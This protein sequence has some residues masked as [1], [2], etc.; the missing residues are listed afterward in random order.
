VELIPFVHYFE[1]F[2]GSNAAIAGFN[3]HTRGYIYD[4]YCSRV[5]HQLETQAD[6]IR[7]DI[8]L[9]SNDVTRIITR[10]SI[11][12]P[13]SL[14]EIE[15]EK[16]NINDSYRQAYAIFQTKVKK[17]DTEEKEINAK[18]ITPWLVFCLLYSILMVLLCG[19]Q[20]VYHCS[21]FIFVLTSCMNFIIGAGFAQNRVYH[22]LLL[23]INS[24]KKWFGMKT[25]SYDYGRG[26]AQ[27][28][29]FFY[30]RRHILRFI[31]ILTVS[32]VAALANS[33]YLERYEAVFPIPESIVVFS[34]LFICAFPLL[35]LIFCAIKWRWE[36]LAPIYR[37]FRSKCKK[38]S[39]WIHRFDDWRFLN[40]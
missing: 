27:Y 23:P 18:R 31:L 20:E 38:T 22:I 9:F 17:C 29:Q 24:L 11:Q 5:Q 35:L 25:D 40:K 10:K 16:K 28:D 32:I 13:V 6:K 3:T 30:V 36:E 21:T 4:F 34:T 2:V 12:S 37:D 14:S 1:I 7:K 15:E 26:G 39:K 33:F 19:F 8:V